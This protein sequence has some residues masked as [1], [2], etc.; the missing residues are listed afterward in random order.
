MASWSVALP[1]AKSMI[2]GFVSV[3]LARPCA[4]GVDVVDVGGLELR[5][6]E[7]FGHRDDRAHSLRV[8]IGD[9]ER[10]GGRP[11]PDHLRQNRR[12]ACIS[13]LWASCLA[14]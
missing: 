12:F 14:V 2:A 4:V 3:V 9:P 6:G 10:V 7:R 5:V 11:V 13:A 8:L 1:T